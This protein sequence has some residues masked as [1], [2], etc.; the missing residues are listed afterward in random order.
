M[1]PLGPI[2][3]EMNNVC[4]VLKNKIKTIRTMY[5]KVNCLIANPKKVVW[6]EMN[7]TYRNCFGTK[8]QIYF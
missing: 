1:L 5:K 8:E 7:Y 6:E 3:K 2:I 4:F